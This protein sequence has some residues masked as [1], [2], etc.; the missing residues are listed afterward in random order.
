MPSTSRVRSTASL[1][2]A[3]PIFARC[4]RP[5]AA[6]LRTE[7]DQPGRFAHGP[8]E[9][10][11][12]TGRTP[13]AV[14]AMMSHPFRWKPLVGERCPAAAHIGIVEQGQAVRRV[15]VPEGMSGTG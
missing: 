12:L 13:G 10:Q 8:E 6:S 1:S 7:G 4:E 15:P 14:V 9:K 3:L 5:R 2:L 11:G